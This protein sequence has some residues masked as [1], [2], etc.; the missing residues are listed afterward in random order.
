MHHEKTIQKH[1]QNVENGDADQLETTIQDMETYGSNQPQTHSN[2]TPLVLPGCHMTK[3]QNISG[4]V[5]GNTPHHQQCPHK[6]QINKNM[7]SVLS[8]IFKV[9]TSIQMSQTRYEA[10]SIQKLYNP[11]QEVNTKESH[12]SRSTRTNLDKKLQILGLSENLRFSPAAYA[13]KHFGSLQNDIY[14]K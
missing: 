12:M 2:G 9:A 8:T 14:R 11:V 10:K 4:V 7:Q 3:Q 5:H 6:L 1:I 13:L